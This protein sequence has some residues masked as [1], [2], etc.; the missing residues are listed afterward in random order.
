MEEVV[1]NPGRIYFQNMRVVLITTSHIRRVGV[2]D[3]I[4]EEETLQIL[5]ENNDFLCKQV[6]EINL[7]PKDDSILRADMLFKERRGRY[8]EVMKSRI[9]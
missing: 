6:Y 5:R 3:A 1:F 7:A 9:G 8:R 2:G 4:K